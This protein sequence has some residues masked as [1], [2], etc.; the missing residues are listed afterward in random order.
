MQDGNK[1]LMFVL[2]NVGDCYDDQQMFEHEKCKN[3]S[4]KVVPLKF[5]VVLHGV[6]IITYK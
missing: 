6:K 4:L 3:S 5:G 2:Y 1:M